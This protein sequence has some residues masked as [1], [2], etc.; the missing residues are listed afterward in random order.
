MKCERCK[1][2]EDCSTGSGL[3]WPCGAYDPKFVTNFEKI[4]AMTVDQLAVFIHAFNPSCR[5][6]FLKAWLQ[7]A[8]EDDADG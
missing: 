2:Y 7:Q 8:V 3:T 1:K 6:S 5:V 4:R